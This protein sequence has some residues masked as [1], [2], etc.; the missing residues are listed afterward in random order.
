MIVDSFSRIR[1]MAY[2]HLSVHCERCDN[3]FEINEEVSEPADNFIH[4][5]SHV[6]R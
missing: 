2:L 5:P 1:E 4:F 3:D 6:F